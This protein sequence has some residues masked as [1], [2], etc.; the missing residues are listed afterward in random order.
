MFMDSAF[1]EAFHQGPRIGIDPGIRYP[2]TATK[3]D[4]INPNKRH[5]LRVSRG[6][7][8]RPWQQFQQQFREK[9]RQGGIDVLESQ[10]PSFSRATIGEY[11]SYLCKSPVPTS[12]PQESDA[13]LSS[14]SSS[15]PTNET[16]LAR[17]TG[18][19]REPWWR[20]GRWRMKRVKNG[21][22]DIAIK[23]LIGMT[24]VTEG[25][26]KPAD[27]RAVFGIGL[28]QF[29]GANSKYTKLLKRFI[30]KTSWHCTGTLQ[31]V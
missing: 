17:I 1:C 31:A 19:Y 23:R 4:P 26:K 21:A 8:N 20:Q 3:I 11:F 28:A 2:I 16:V 7:L 14:S 5:V 15:T 27:N 18:F 30:K 22:M 12:V 13:H 24:G 10:M 9:K 6:F 29:S 25:I